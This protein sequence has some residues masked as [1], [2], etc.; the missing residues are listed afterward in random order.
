MSYGMDENN[1]EMDSYYIP[2]QLIPSGGADMPLVGNPEANDVEVD[3]EP[4]DTA[5][6]PDDMPAADIYD[7]QAEAEARA[8]ELGG[9]DFIAIRL[10]MAVLFICLLNPMRNMMQL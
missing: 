2:A 7:T 1:K 3:T 6:N 9:S 8:E 10:M 4:I 5:N